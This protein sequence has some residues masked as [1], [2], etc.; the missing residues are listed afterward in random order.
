MSFEG[1][2]CG[3]PEDLMRKQ[4]MYMKAGLVWMGD[5]FMRSQSVMNIR[6][7]PGSDD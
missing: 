3:K 7:A 5:F 2:K 4:M 1:Q 6:L